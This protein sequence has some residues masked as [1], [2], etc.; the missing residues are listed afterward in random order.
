VT[1]DTATRAWLDRL[2][3]RDHDDQPAPP[4]GHVA[5]EGANHRPADPTP[6]S[7]RDLIRH[8]TGQQ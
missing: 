2:T 8:L 3:G 4:A 6:N 5:D 1:D 7:R